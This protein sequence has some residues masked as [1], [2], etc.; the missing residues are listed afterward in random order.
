MERFHI[1]NMITIKL[2][3]LLFQMEKN[4]PDALRKQSSGINL[5]NNEAYIVHQ[6]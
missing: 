6:N 5:L 4:I 1:M 2:I 3:N